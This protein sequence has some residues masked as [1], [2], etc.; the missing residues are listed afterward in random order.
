MTAQGAMEPDITIL[1]GMEMKVA[2]PKAKRQMKK[3]MVGSVPHR[4]R[5]Y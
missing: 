5:I 2:C 3:L 4:I 1:D